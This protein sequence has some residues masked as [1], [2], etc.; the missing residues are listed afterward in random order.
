MAHGSEYSYRILQL[1][2]ASTLSVLN[3][4]N[5]DLERFRKENAFAL[6]KIDW[7]SYRVFSATNSRFIKHEINKI[8]YS[9]LPNKIPGLVSNFI[10]K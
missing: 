5:N 10:T 6:H 2:I 9:I 4:R 8:K 7:R 1:F 3:P